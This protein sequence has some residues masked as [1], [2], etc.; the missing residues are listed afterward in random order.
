MKPLAATFSDG[1]WQAFVSAG[2]FAICAL[3]A[4]LH[5]ELSASPS[6]GPVP[7]LVYIGAMLALAASASF[8]FVIY[9]LN[10]ANNRRNDL[11][12]KFKSGLFEFDR[13]LKDYPSTVG[14]VRDCQEL[15]WELKKLRSDDFP[16]LKWEE[17]LA[18]LGEYWNRET[19]AHLDDPNLEHKVLGYLSYLEE[20]VSE[21]GLMCI[22]QIIVGVYT[23]TVRKAFALLACLVITAVVTAGW[24]GLAPTWLI[25]SV[26]VFFGSF[27][28]LILHEV[29]WSIH[30]EGEE[31]LDFVERGQES[32]KAAK[33]RGNEAQQSAQADSHAS[34]GPAA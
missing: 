5:P 24:G 3:L 30:R 8:G 4:Y 28:A 10:H 11:Y 21:I 20:L 25:N 18:D 34:S 32:A 6:S 16:L 7:V 22:R 31:N 15:S 2:L 17:L 12:L 27:V 14:L 1:V 26:P 23:N 33:E 9:L 13:F 19:P 29:S